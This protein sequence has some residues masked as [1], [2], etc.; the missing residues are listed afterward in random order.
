MV[1][2][3]SPMVR[4]TLAPGAAVPVTELVAALMD[5]P[6]NTCVGLAWVKLEPP[7]VQLWSMV[8]EPL[9]RALIA[10]LDNVF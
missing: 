5:N 3:S 7:D 10:S 2:V 8:Y 9:T 4:V 1:K 6:D